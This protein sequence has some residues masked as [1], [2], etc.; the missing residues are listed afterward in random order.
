MATILT[1]CSLIST[2]SPTWR[3]PSLAKADSSITTALPAFRSE[4]R[5]SRIFHG[6]P[7]PDSTLKPTNSMFSE[8]PSRL[9]MFAQPR[10]SL[11]AAATP[12]VALTVLNLSSEKGTGKSKLAEFFDVI[13]M[14]ALVLSMMIEAFCMK[15]R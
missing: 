6:P 1:R 9:R 10:I 11:S 14:S 3:V 7:T 2:Y 13:Q 8:P 4:S 15:P 5:P 12:G